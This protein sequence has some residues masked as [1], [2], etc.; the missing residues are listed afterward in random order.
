MPLAGVHIQTQHGHAQACLRPQIPCVA[1]EDPVGI[2]S[3][4]ETPVYRGPISAQQQIR[5]VTLGLLQSGGAPPIRNFRVIAANQNLGH[6]PTAKIGWTRV[7]RKIQK[8]AG[9]EW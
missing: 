3:F 1:R 4:T 8:G 7:M 6:L 2:A 9:L 5:P